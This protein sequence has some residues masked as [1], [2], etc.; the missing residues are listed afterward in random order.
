MA[1]VSLP[2]GFRFHPTDEELVAYYLNRKIN[3]RTIELEVIPEVDLYKCEP[4]ELPDKSFLPS[5]DLEWYFFSPRDR[6]YPNGSRTNRAT[7]AGYWK[8]TGKDR[9]VNS[10][11]R[12]VGMKKTLVYYRGRAP[13]GSRTDWV[14]HEYRLDERECESSNGL[15]DAYALCRVFKK[16]EPGPKIIEHY[17][18]PCEEHKQW[19]LNDHSSNMTD[20]SPDGMGD[21]LDNGGYHFQPS[22]CLQTMIQSP[23]D[24]SN[25]WMQFLTEEALSSTT[26]TFQNTSCFSYVPSKV[27]VALECARLQERFP[28]P[29]L[30]VED[31]PQLHM[32]DPKILRTTN[33]SQHTTNRGDILHEILSVASASQELIN[34]PNFHEDIW[35][36]RI[37]PHFNE[38]LSSLNESG[39]GEGSSR[40][41]AKSHELDDQSSFVDI[42]ELE[43]EFKD[44]KKG[45]NLRDVKKLGEN[46][47]EV[48][49]EVRQKDCSSNPQTEQI[50]DDQ[51]THQGNFTHES[52]EID[53]KPIYSQSQE[54]DFSIGF[55]NIHQHD[56]NQYEHHDLNNNGSPS[57]DV[58]HEMIQF[59]QGLLK[60]SQTVSKTLFH[61]I[62]PANKINIHLNPIDFMVG[63][64][65]SSERARSRVSIFENFKNFFCNKLKKGST[66]CRGGA[67]GM[68][69]LIELLLASSFYQGGLLEQSNLVMEEL[70]SRVESMEAESRKLISYEGRKKADNMKRMKWNEVKRIWIP[71]IRGK[72][73][74]R[75]FMNGNLLPWVSMLQPSH[76]S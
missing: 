47:I 20:L 43:D 72:S 29:S 56:F 67:T 2:P 14:M 57:F 26:A 5:K 32:T 50:S 75:I 16:S 51:E 65:D 21:Y 49:K 71:N 74:S 10:Q 69:S 28:L 53:S 27:D 60:S 24:A 62:A 40:F 45:K 41:M 42:S 22:D 66:F 39:N 33:Y 3:G 61:H 9:K 76:H 12:A 52:T 37:T 34:N 15:Q 7:Q 59:N 46:L 58:Y 1:P 55:I 13:H 63:R 11:K 4:W 8:A 54:D 25:S 70:P 48:N 17:G 38:P 31:Y 35:T 64:F 30:E 68:L 6:K 36:T 18:A 19:I 73:I 44:Q 23:F